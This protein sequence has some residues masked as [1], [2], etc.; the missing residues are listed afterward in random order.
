MYKTATA[1]KINKRLENKASAH[2]SNNCLY[3][4][5]AIPKSTVQGRPFPR[6]GSLN[7]LNCMTEGLVFKVRG[8]VYF[9]LTRLY[10]TGS[11][12]MQGFVVLTYIVRILFGSNSRPSV[13]QLYLTIRLVRVRQSV[14]TGLTPVLHLI[15]SISLRGPGQLRSEVVT[16]FLLPASDI[17]LRIHANVLTPWYTFDTIES[18]TDA[19][20]YTLALPNRRV[21]FS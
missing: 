5:L 2:L 13:S 6:V 17:P 1:P 11:I 8:K 10:Y 7:W 9:L 19:R 21:S 14:C 18:S 20:E 4:G 15:A 12:N 3:R 16:Q